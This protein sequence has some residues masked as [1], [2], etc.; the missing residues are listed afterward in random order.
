MWR[1]YL[2]QAYQDSSVFVSGEAVWWI[3]TA[4]IGVP[5]AIIAPKVIWLKNFFEGV[6]ER[7]SI[8]LYIYLPLSFIS[9]ITVLVRNIY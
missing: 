4:V 7:T 6:A 1:L 5:L 8:F 2:F 9:L 3:V